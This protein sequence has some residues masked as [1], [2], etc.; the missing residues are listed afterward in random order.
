MNEIG[1][2]RSF[3]TVSSAG[4]RQ[5]LLALSL[6]VLAIVAIFYDARG[7]AARRNDEQAAVE[8]VLARLPWSDLA[9]AGGARHLRFPSLEDPGA[10]FADAPASPD[11]DPGGGAIAPPRDVY[12]TEAREKAARRQAEKNAR[13][14]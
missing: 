6:A 11:L 5:P 14:P 1:R 7:R 8:R 4:A 12:T 10:A 3:S 13:T 2:P 9:L